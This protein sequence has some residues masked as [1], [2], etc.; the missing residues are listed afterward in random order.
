[1]TPV[2][3]A[4]ETAVQRADGSHGRSA[5]DSFTVLTVHGGERAA[6]PAADRGLRVSLGPRHP[7]AFGAHA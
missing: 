5:P 2:S 4:G 6:E 3:T 1:M 7:A